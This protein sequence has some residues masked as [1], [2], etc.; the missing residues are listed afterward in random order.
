MVWLS[1]VLMARCRGPDEFWRKRKIFRLA[2]HYLGRRRNCYSIAIRNVHRALVYQTKARKQRFLDFRNLWMA[3]IT[4][5]ALQHNVH[6]FAFREG[7]DRIGVR[8]N[9]KT[10]ADLASWEPRS[11]AALAAL[12]KQKT[13]TDGLNVVLD[14]GL[15]RGVDLK[16]RLFLRGKLDK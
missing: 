5:G 4:A 1:K 12:A 8:L 7:L 11:F 6:P 13:V 2:A 10:L 9:R 3:R 14:G 16:H 15:P